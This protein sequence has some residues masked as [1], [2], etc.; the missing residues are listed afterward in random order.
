MKKINLTDYFAFFSWLFFLI[1]VYYPKQTQSQILPNCSGKQLSNKACGSISCFDSRCQ[2]CSESS[3]L[4]CL[5]CSDPY[6]VSRVDGQ[7]SCIMPC[8]NTQVETDHYNKALTDTFS[9]NEDVCKVDTCVDKNCFSCLSGSPKQCLVCDSSM[10]PV[11]DTASDSI[12]CKNCSN[13]I[14]NCSTCSWGSF[15]FKC[16][17]YTSKSGGFLLNVN[18]TACVSC[19]KAITH[20]AKCDGINTC[21]ECDK[22]YFLVNGKCTSC[23]RNCEVCSEKKICATCK[24]GYFLSNPSLCLLCNLQITN[25][26][27]CSDNTNCLKCKASY[28]LSSA[29]SIFLLNISC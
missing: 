2:T 1:L 20:C 15:C 16:D 26:M 18:A 12:V 25:C 21:S 8:S 13:L 29:T 10:Y 27:S 9:G 7:G 11:Y 24:K 3:K 5:I 23:L 28:Y 19:Q 6:K 22:G 4:D 14:L 17:G